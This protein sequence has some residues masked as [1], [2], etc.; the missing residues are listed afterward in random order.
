MSDEGDI[1][2]ADQD[3]M[4]GASS[5]TVPG[6]PKAKNFIETAKGGGRKIQTG[7]PTNPAKKAQFKARMKAIAQRGAGRHK[8]AAAKKTI[9]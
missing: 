5:T 2:A 3:S 4:E 6:K 7:K 9:Y 1:G 8:N